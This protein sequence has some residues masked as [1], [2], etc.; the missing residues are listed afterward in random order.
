MTGDRFE[1]GG[2]RVGFRVCFVH[3]STCNSSNKSR[4]KNHEITRGFSFGVQVIVAIID[5]NRAINTTRYKP[6]MGNEINP[7]KFELNPDVGACK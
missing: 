2:L 1:V 7:G 4:K 6:T 5:C 3:T